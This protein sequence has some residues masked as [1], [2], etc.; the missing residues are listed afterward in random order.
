MSSLP[1]ELQSLPIKIFLATVLN[2]TRVLLCRKFCANHA[3]STALH[4]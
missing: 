3:T 4:M 1:A 2:H